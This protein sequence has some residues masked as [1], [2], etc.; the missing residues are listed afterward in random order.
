MTDSELEGKRRAAERA[1]D[2]LEPGMVVG[3]GTGSTAQLA[4]AEIGGRLR[5]GLLRDIRGVPTSRAAERHALA[6]GVPLTTLERHP[7]LD[8]TIDGADEVDREGNLLKGAGGALLREKIVATC[9]RRLVI[10]VDRTKLVDRLGVAHPLPV[11]VVAF[12]WN[13]HLDAVRALG[14]EPVLRMTEAGAPC[15]TDE[16]HYIIDARF[17][18][19]LPAPEQVE[20][21]LRRRAGVVETGLFLGFAPRVIVGNAGDAG[22]E[23]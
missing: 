16:G 7:T 1:V 10:V 18:A 22:V 5:R 2:L 13:T 23:R 4:I 8:L 21:V 11:E 6:H 20:G 3:L 15:Q 17:P 14:G 19:G 12:G 9:S